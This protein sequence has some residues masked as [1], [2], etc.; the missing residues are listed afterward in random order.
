[1]DFDCKTTCSL[2][3]KSFTFVVRQDRPIVLHYFRWSFL[4]HILRDQI[5]NTE[6]ND[7]GQPEYTWTSIV[8][9]VVK[10]TRQKQ[11]NQIT[12]VKIST[13]IDNI[14]FATVS[15]RQKWTTE[16]CAQWRIGLRPTA[17][18]LTLT[19]EVWPPY[20]QSQESYGHD[21]DTCEGPG[22]RSLSSKVRI[23][24]DRWTDRRTEVIALPPVLTRSVKMWT[25]GKLKRCRISDALSTCADSKTILLEMSKINSLVSHTHNL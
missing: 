17:L 2:H 6:C 7:I 11:N 22:Q 24:T 10:N 20:L 9:V 1:M 19:L 3:I 25:A 5:I 15:A 4:L 8:T 13:N 18:D 21:P 14:V 23:E 12:A 16:N